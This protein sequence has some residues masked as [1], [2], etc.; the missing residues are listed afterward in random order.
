M[1]CDQVDDF[2]VILFYFTFFV[3]YLFGLLRV[4]V[5]KIFIF[6]QDIN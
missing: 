4:A 5:M 6:S 2:F 3:V 1:V